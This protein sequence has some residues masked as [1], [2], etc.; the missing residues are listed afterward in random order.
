MYDGL[1]NPHCERL[2]VDLVAVRAG[3]FLHSK[4]LVIWVFV[5]RHG[6][7]NREIVQFKEHPAALGAWHRSFSVRFW[8]PLRSRSYAKILD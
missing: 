6:P 7:V 1:M 4:V 2:V 5:V 8:R 3:Y